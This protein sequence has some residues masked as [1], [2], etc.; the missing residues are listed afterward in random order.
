MY[1][2]IEPARHAPSDKSC[3]YGCVMSV[4][5]LCDRDHVPFRASAERMRPSSVEAI[6]ISENRAYWLRAVALWFL[7]MAAETLHGLWRAKVLALWIGDFPA[8]DVGVF[9]GSLIILL[10]TWALIGWIPARNARML[11]LVG[12]T[13]MVL[14][15]AYE[16]LL[17][18]FVFNQSLN[19]IAS[20]FDVL[21]G[22]LLPLGLLF[23]MFSPLLAAYFR[24]RIARH[25]EA[26]A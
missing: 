16:L 9:T 14:T 25:P 6:M 4:T 11:L 13:W 26:A 12:V 7:L 3:F 15:I 18:R 24:G 8:R 19:E 5:T 10:I 1:A 21:N 23:M 17:G 2:E 22:R 20:Q